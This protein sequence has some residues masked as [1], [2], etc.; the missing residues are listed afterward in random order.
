MKQLLY[1]IIPFILLSG[2]SSTNLVFMTITNPA[3]VSIPSST[4]DIGLVKRCK[5]TDSN[6]T[7]NKIHQM[8]TLETEAILREGSDQAISGL[9]EALLENQRFD[10][11]ILMDSIQLTSPGSG[12]FPSPLPWETVEKICSEN[13][14]SVLFSLEMFDTELLITPMSLPT[15]ISNPSDILN[16]L[17]RVRMTTLVKVGYRIYYPTSRVILDQFITTKSLE[18]NAS[19]AN[20]ILAIEA[21]VGRKEAIKQTANQAG[22]LYALRILPVNLRVSRD[23][24]VRGKTSSF[25]VAKRRAQS[26]NWDGAA[27]IWLRETNSSKRKTAGRACYNMAI[28]N[29]INGNLDEAIKWSQRSY[30]DYRVKLALQYLNILRYR[31]NQQNILN[32]QNN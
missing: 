30:E 2:C 16:T 24:F 9:K 21:L 10:N 3:P 27:E 32:N 13:K 1:L 4:R 8:T 11:V 18:F 22:R 25:K 15:S 31:K 28:I 5:P 26:G 12:I 14:F 20:P 29:E 23:Y 19:G 7:F 6:K 17:H